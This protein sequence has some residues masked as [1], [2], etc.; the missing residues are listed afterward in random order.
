MVVVVSFVVV[1]IVVDP[2]TSCWC[3]WFWLVDD[4]DDGIDDDDGDGGGGGAGGGGCDDGDA[5]D[6]TNRLVHTHHISYISRPI[7]MYT[8]KRLAIRKPENGRG[9]NMCIYMLV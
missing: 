4:D 3:R 5:G 8:R 9:F 1:A 6:E 2:D 7:L